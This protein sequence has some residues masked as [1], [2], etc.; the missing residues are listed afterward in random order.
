MSS[1]AERNE[2]RINANKD[3]FFAALDDFKKYYVY[4][5]KNPE[6]DEYHNYYTES[7]GQLQSLSRD[8]NNLTKSIERQIVALDEK[9]TDINDKMS[10]EK[11]TNNDL[12]NRA[13]NMN[14]TRN[15]SD[16]LI[17]DAKSKYNKQY[18]ANWE[19][20]IGIVIVGTILARSFNA[21]T[22]TA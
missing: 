10:N 13:Y 1:A 3:S 7:V 2:E 16:V 17:S 18:Y 8:L 5:K 14:G 15:G 19:I 12:S 9:M 6:V 20:V 21:P 11:D 4:Y 22:R